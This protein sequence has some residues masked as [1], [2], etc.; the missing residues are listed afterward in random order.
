MYAFQ[1]KIEKA[2]ARGLRP[3]S[4]D[5]PPLRLR[6][7]LCSQGGEATVLC[8]Q[9]CPVQA[10][11]RRNQQFAGSTPTCA[12]PTQ[13]EYMYKESTSVASDRPSLSGPGPARDEKD[14]AA[15]RL[16]PRTCGARSP[17]T[18]PFLQRTLAGNWG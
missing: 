7:G 10:L 15:D 17:C 18:T 13:V 12:Q 2:K 14:G 16:R 3:I 6:G 8:T 11:G 5:L 1:L 9:S 4:L